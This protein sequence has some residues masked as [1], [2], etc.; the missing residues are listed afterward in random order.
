MHDPMPMAPVLAQFALAQP[1]AGAA[2]PAGGA[3]MMGGPSTGAAGPTAT[4]TQAPGGLTSGGGTPQPRGMFDPSMMLIVVMVGMLAL[5]MWTASRRQKKERA[6]R[7]NL[8]N[9]LRKGDTVLT[10]GGIKG[11]IAENPDGKDEIVL[12][13]DETTRNRIRFVKTAVTQVVRGDSVIDVKSDR[14]GSTA[15]AGGAAVAAGAS[16]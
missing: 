16:A 5:M 10:I 13:V 6:E 2:P 15:N 9:S 8:M 14:Q 12:T 4:G 1:E 3:E 11:V 7:E